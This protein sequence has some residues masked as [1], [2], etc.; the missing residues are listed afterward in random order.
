M[1]LW[2]ATALVAGVAM[3]YAAA[4]VSGVA[5]LFATLLCEKRYIHYLIAASADDRADVDDYIDEARPIAF[6]ARFQFINTF[7]PQ[8]GPWRDVLVD[9]WSAEDHKTLAAVA[10]GR[11]MGVPLERTVF[12]S[13]LEDGTRLTTSDDFDEGD[14]AGSKG[15]L[16]RPDATFRELLQTH[17]DRLDRAATPAVE[18]GGAD[19]L[20]ALEDLE[21]LHV[22]ELVHAGFAR[23]RD[24]TH[25]CWSYTFRGAW[26]ICFRTHPAEVRAGRASERAKLSE[27]AE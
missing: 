26:E 15:P 21:R 12:Y 3:V 1:E 2:Y 6:A 24:L 23:F 8:R 18:F 9:V 22:Q 10:A 4:K 14:P 27:S 13:V 19:P 7:K 11:M 17:R 20:G 25:N 16:V 5:L